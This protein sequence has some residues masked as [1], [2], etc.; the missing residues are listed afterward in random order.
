MR[1]KYDLTHVKT[2]SAV[3]WLDEITPQPVRWLWHGWLP[4]GKLAVLEGD[5]GLGKTMLWCAIVAA[6]SREGG[7][8]P[9]NEIVDEPVS[10]LV[11]SA[12]DD[13]ADTLVPRLAAAGANLSRV[14]TLPLR[15]DGRGQPIPFTIPDDVGRLG[16][17]LDASDA[18]LIV[19]DPVAAF[20]SE[21]IKTHNDASLRRAMQPL[22][23]LAQAREAVVLLLRHWNKNTGAQA[24]HRGG[25]S[26]AMTAAARSVMQVAADPDQPD[27]LRVLAQAKANLARRVPSVAFRVTG[28][29]LDPEVPVLRWAG[30]SRWTADELAGQD[31]DSRRAAPARKEAAAFVREVL[32]QGPVAAGEVFRQA[33][34]VGITRNT[35]KRAAKQLG[36]VHERL[37]DESSGRTKEWQWKLPEDQNAPGA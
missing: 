13:L 22:A 5:P 4:R 16:S 8:L 19:I 25:G 37:R 11:V 29:A 28:S 6:L 12:E 34:E 1:I 3:T 18:K 27:D 33:T 30:P 35:V 10:S 24:I 14:A 31:G 23:E 17:A 20:V 26:V 9:L 2:E 7:R 32:A 36:V 21:N 15:S